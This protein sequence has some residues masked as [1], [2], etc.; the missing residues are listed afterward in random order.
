MT[1]IRY[2]LEALALL[3]LMVIFRLM[4]PE[5]ASNTGGWI[6]RQIGPRLAASRKALR[7]IE[8]A[9]PELDR[10]SREKALTEMWD[11]LGRVMAEYPHLESLALDHVEISGA[12]HLHEA[13]STGKGIAFI[14]GHIGNWEI[15]SM[16]SLV[17]LNVAADISYRAPNNPWVDRL[18]MHMRGAGGRIRAFPKSRTGGR[19]MIETIKSGRSLGI[20]I[21]QKYREGIDAPFFGI[22]ARTNPFFAQVAVKYGAI[23]LPIRCERLEGCRFRLN[24]Y[25]PLPTEGKSVD[26]IVAQA[27]ALLEGWIRER[28]GQWL[29]LH[30][31]WKD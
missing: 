12:D 21:D 11:N 7:N 23:L 22:P 17:Q 24:I 13:L 3:T 31:R 19:G 16:A 2:L 26:E 15:N 9:L 29:W 1:Q 14:G 18:L 4:P 20:L 5:A 27:H 6:G 25:E 28:P 8:R 30:R 10:T